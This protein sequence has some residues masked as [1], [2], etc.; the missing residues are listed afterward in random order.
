MAGFAGLFAGCLTAFVFTVSATPETSKPPMTQQAA[1]REVPAAE[2]L[3][4]AE[5]LRVELKS[6]TPPL[7]IDVREPSEHVGGAIEGDK[8]VP[9]GEL[10]QRYG[11]LPKDKPIVIYCRSGG[12]SMRAVSF[13]Q[14]QGFKNVRSLSGGYE[15]WKLQE[16]TEKKSCC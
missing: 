14:E 2:P 11:E 15:G 12:R 1:P 10:P 5:T 4:G 16:G 7:L 6:K 13:L 8:N 9:L 3:I